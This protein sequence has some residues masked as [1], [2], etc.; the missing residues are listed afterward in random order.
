VLD[1]SSNCASSDFPQTIY[2]SEQCRDHPLCGLLF[3]RVVTHMTFYGPFGEII[4][5]TKL[6]LKLFISLSSFSLYTGAEP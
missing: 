4:A 6:A 2:S 5:G 3:H 1:K